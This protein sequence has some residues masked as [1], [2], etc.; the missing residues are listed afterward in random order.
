MPVR[1]LSAGRPKRS[2]SALSGSARRAGRSAGLLGF[3]L[4][5]GLCVGIAPVSAQA[6]AAQ[7]Q[8]PTLLDAEQVIYD[9]KAGVVTA[10]G[11]VELTQG[12]RAVRADKIV[13]D[14]NTKVVTAT[15]N[16]RLREPSGDFIFAD[17]VELTDDMRDAFVENVRVLMTD[18]GR[19]AGNEGERRGGRLFRVNR[20][21]YS[22]CELCKE[23]PTRAPV[24]RVRAARVVHD[25]EEKEVRYRDAY[26]EMFGVPVAYTPY[27]SHPDPTVDRRSGFLAPTYGSKDDMGAFIR[28][29]YYI[30][31]APDRAV[32]AATAAA[33]AGIP[34][35]FRRRPPAIERLDHSIGARRVERCQQR[36]QGSRLYRRQR[37]VQYR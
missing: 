26:L 4:A 19:M 37:P 3:A 18:N 2:K 25:K 10:T 28:T 30:D 12:L 22:P 14:R 15:G 7:R 23:D 8:D 9:E 5:A 24:W 27:L 17:Y 29:S 6:P 11:A 20:G 35:A 31:I 36:R 21:V 32:C 13:Y 33:W 16:V 1:L 34:Q